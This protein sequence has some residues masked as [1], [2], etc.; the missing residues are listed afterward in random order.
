MTGFRDQP[1]ANDRHNDHLH[2]GFA[3]APNR[4]DYPQLLATVRAEAGEKRPYLLGISGHGGAGKTTL[5]TRLAAE[6]GGLRIGTDSLYAADTTQRG[7]FDLHDWAQILGLVGQL[8]GGSTPV[9]YTTRTFDGIEG[10]KELVPPAVVIIEGI[11]LIRPEIVEL[12][13]ATIWIDLPADVAG[14]RAKRRNR[15][16][17]DCEAEIQL[18]D[19]RWIPEAL[20]YQDQLRPEQLARF[21]IAAAGA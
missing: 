18:W 2:L 1:E 10:T 6:V 8:R 12:V 13:D 4:I 14:E 11:R 7:L 15:E 20:A 16:Q 5:A 3:A 9:R 17:G 21:V 19:T